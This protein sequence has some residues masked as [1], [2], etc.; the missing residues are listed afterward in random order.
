MYVGY[1]ENVK[2]MLTRPRHVVLTLRHLAL[3]KYPLERS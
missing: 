1:N 3:N 2:T